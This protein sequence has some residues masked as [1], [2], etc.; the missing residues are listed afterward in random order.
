MAERAVQ[1]RKSQLFLTSIAPV[2]NTYDELVKEKLEKG[3]FPTTVTGIIK[4]IGLL[5]L[6]FSLGFFLGQS[7]CDNTPSWY[8]YL[9][10]AS[11]GASILI[12]FVLFFLFS[13]GFTVKQPGIW[14]YLDVVLNL[15]FSLNTIICSVLT[16]KECT[17]H[18]SLTKIPGPFGLADDEIE[19]TPP[20]RKS[21][22]KGQD[23]YLLDENHS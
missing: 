19:A 7:G 13:L 4:I 23:Q 14:I 12:Q 17:G 6:L 18:G 5:M 20:P 2:T 3:K 10:P 16:L 8:P 21:E 22:R 9:F 11:L 1:R 15:A